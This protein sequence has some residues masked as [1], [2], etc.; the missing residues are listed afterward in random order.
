MPGDILLIRSGWKEVY[1][2]KKPEE[3]KIEALREE[4]QGPHDVQRWAGISQEEANVNW[5]HDYYFA[6]VGRDSVTFE[7]MAQFGR[8]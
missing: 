8:R 2:S 3:R 1:D 5:I 6:A 7:S 4:I